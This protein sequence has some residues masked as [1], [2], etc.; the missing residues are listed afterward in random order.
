MLDMFGPYT[1]QEASAG[2]SGGLGLGLFICEQI[3][4]AHGGELSVTSTH[5]EGTTFTALNPI[6]ES[7][8]LEPVAAPG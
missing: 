1:R 4:R 5:E 7:V 8:P 3:V 2:R 6:V